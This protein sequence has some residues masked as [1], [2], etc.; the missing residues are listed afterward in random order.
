MMTSLFDLAGRRALVTGASRGIGRAIALSLARHGADVAVTARSEAELASLGDEIAVL[1][2]R[3]VTLPADL[4]AESAPELVVDDA[5][6]ALGGLDILINNAGIDH[7]MSAL[8]FDL[9]AWR[10]VARFNSETPF[11]MARAAARRFVGAAGGKVVMIASVLAVVGLRNDSA[12]IASKHAILGVTRALALEWA[13]KNIQVNAIGPGFIRTDMTRSTWDNEEGRKYVL[14]RTPVNRLGEP[15]DIA[16]AAVF[17]SSKASDFMTGQ[18]VLV[19][20]GWS[21]Q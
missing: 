3:A 1:G 20:G 16:G 5:A 17:L 13:R 9:A 6:T 2:R 21:A 4:F 19:D 7:E 18:L 8:E 11:R 15:E 12:Y 10:K 14:A